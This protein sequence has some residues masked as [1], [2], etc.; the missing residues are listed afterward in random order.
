[1][2]TETIK[3]YSRSQMQKYI[4]HLADLEQAEQEAR[5]HGNWERVDFIG[6][7]IADTRDHIAR[8]SK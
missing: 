5:A 8:L 6:N 2:T 4:D 1:M 7:A 3:I